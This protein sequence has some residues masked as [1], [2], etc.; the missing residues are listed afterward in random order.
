MRIEILNSEKSLLEALE[1]SGLNPEYQCRKG[2]CGSCVASLIEGDV[3]YISTP[4]AFHREREVILCCAK[5]V[6]RVVVGLNE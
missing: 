1:A 5:A 3:E 2:Y 6:G 4:R